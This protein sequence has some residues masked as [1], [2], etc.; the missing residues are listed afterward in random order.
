MRKLITILSVLIVMLSTSCKKPSDYYS[1]A[2]YSGNMAI[3]LQQME[4]RIERIQE[5]YA[6]EPINLVSRISMRL[7]TN[8]NYL[9]ELKE[10]L[11]NSDTDQMIN[12][13][14]KHLEYDLESVKNPK[15][16]EFLNEIDK[17]LTPED[18]QLVIEKYETHLDALYEQKNE[19]WKKY[20]KELTKYAK[21]NNIKEN[22][23]GPD[24][25]PIENTK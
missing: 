22:F 3:S 13:A 10:F 14:I 6:P 2:V 20:D 8:E 11:G 23:Y 18:L 4:S 5:G 25:K 15:T 16:I 19:L 17:K 24:L 9:S 1:K 21:D 12:A 7:A